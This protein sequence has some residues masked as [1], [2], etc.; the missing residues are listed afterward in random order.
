MPA[1]RLGDS[2]SHRNGQVVAMTRGFINWPKLVFILVPLLIVIV[3]TV[4]LVAE[5]LQSDADK[6][7]RLV[8]ESSS[9]KEN[10]TIQQYLYMTIYHRK[11]AGEPISIEGWGANSGSVDGAPIAVEFRFSDSSREYVAIWEADLRR[12]SV[13]PKNEAALDLSFH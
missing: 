7:I 11:T 13:T 8:R 12:R 2:K 4:V 1:L 6:A 3:D 5:H 10:F 9:R